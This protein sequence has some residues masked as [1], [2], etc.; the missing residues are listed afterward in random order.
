[1]RVMSSSALAS[2]VRIFS[3]TWSGALARN[4][5]FPSLPSACAFSFSAAP[6]SFVRRLR[7]AATSIV[8]DR[9]SATVAPATGRDAVA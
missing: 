1:M 8:P 5:S 7:S 6:R 4:A 3:T 9:S 2:R